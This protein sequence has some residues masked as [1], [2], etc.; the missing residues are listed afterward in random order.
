[1]ASA[2]FQNT[3]DFPKHHFNINEQSI[4]IRKYQFYIH[5][6]SECGVESK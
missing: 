3:L 1:M 4:S 6:D 2:F 5:Q